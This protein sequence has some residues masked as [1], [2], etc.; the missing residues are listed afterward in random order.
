MNGPDKLKT[1]VQ[2]IK[3]VGPGLASV[4][5][6]RG[7]Y[8][9]SDI[10]FH[11]PFRY[12]DS[13]KID[14]IKQATPGKERPSSPRWPHPGF[15]LRAPAHIRGHHYRRDRRYLRQMVPFPRQYDKELQ[16]GAWVLFAGELTEYNGMKQFVHPDS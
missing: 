8:T 9:V 5:A 16:E 2:Y 13:R 14:N 12:V 11:F 1:P 4:L 15:P 6:K 3:G 10:L 7:L